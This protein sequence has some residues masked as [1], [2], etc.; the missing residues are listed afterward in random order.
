VIFAPIKKIPA[1]GVSCKIYGY[2]ESVLSNDGF[3]LLADECNGRML[4][5]Q[6]Q[7]EPYAGEVVTKIDFGVFGAFGSHDVEDGIFQH[8]R[9]NKHAR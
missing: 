5:G 6:L 1:R 3:V 8:D 2:L 4:T 7:A 9:E